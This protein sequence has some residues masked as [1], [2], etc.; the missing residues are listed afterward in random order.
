MWPLP[1]AWTA[2]LAA[3]AV[4]A[5]FAAGSTAA[6]W[7]AAG[8]I[9]RVKRESAERIASGYRAAERV[10][11]EATEQYAADLARLRSAPPRVVRVCPT[12]VSAAPAGV[13]D[14]PAAVAG[15][16]AGEDIGPVLAACLA[17]LY[18]YRALSHAVAG[19]QP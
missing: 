12:S 16:G 13:G 4:V 10:H 19:R 14:A 6:S 15:A 1:A 8:E 11:R 2:G 18:R 5:A 7:R 3:T 17:E 9:E